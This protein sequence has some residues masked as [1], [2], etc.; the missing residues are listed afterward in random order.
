MEGELKE[1]EDG[2]T[3]WEVKENDGGKTK[4]KVNGRKGGMDDGRRI[5][6][7]RR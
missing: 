1:Q 5:M 6:E 7:E 2:W 4:L 3:V